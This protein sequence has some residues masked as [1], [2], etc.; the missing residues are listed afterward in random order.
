MI[1]PK[2]KFNFNEPISNSFKLSLNRLSAYISD[3][4]VTERNYKFWYALEDD[5]AETN[6]D[7][8]IMKANDDNETFNDGFAN[9]L[10]NILLAMIDKI[11]PRDYELSEIAHKVN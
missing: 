5:Q 3:F 1:R 9:R 2:E 6:V 11:T 4:N 7:D 8:I 10:D